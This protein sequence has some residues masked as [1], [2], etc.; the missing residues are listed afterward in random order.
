VRLV[1]AT[2][3][4]YAESA[5][6]AGKAFTRS[7]WALLVLLCAFP[8][9]LAA[10]RLTAPLGFAGG[11]IYAL[12]MDAVAGTYLACLQDA[13]A[14]RRSMGPSIVRANLGRY[15]WEIVRVN[16]P[17]YLATLLVGIVSPALGLAL[18]VAIFFFLNPL[19]EMIGRAGADGVDLIR[20][21]ARFVLKDGIE[22]FVAMAVAITPLVLLVSVQAGLGFG[23][24]F[25]FV[26]AGGAVFEAVGRSPVG[27]VFGL[28]GVA[29][30]HLVMLF[31]GAL[32]VRLSSSGRRGRAWQEHFR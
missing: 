8:V 12:L 11:M 13:L 26:Y 14:M 5:S 27:V 28:V 1:R 19:P 10:A 32:Y 2:L 24:S 6:D 30:T 20:E 15:T 4:I 18:G 31:R 3:R 22:W 16:F 7:A 17:I 25:G 23:A 29:G 21:A 9:L